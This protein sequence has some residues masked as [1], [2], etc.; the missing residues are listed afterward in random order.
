M[1]DK[2]IHILGMIFLYQFIQFQIDNSSKC[3]ICV[4]RELCNFKN[5][6]IRKAIA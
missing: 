6:E 1:I 4:I 5:I 3:A 2:S